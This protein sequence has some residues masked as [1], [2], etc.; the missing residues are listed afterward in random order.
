MKYPVSISLS[1][2]SLTTKNCICLH[3]ALPEK[4][5]LNLLYTTDTEGENLRQTD[6]TAAWETAIGEEYRTVLAAVDENGLV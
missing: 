3:P 5:L 2:C 1:A 4:L 6:I